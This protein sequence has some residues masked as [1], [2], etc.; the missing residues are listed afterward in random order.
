MICWWVWH[1][2]DFRDDQWWTWLIC[3]GWMDIQYVVI[4]LQYVVV[5]WF[6]FIYKCIFQLFSKK[7]YEWQQYQKSNISIEFDNWFAPSQHTSLCCWRVKLL[8]FFAFTSPQQMVMIFHRIFVVL[9]MKIEQLPPFY[10][11]FFV[12]KAHFLQKKMGIREQ[13]LIYHNI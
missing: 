3:V 4:T 10:I 6:I 11:I 13:L 12:K 9:I 5:V 8:S 7:R 2:F 1:L